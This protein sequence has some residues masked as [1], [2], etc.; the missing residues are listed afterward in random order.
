[1]T[2]TLDSSRTR[3]ARPAVP[4][5]EKT[6]DWVAA[7]IISADQARRID[8]AEGDLV[9]VAAG[10]ERRPG[11]SLAVEALGY[12]GG[13]VVV[14]SS[15]LIA[16]RYWHQLSDGARTS[17]VAVA[18]L[19][20][21]G[22]GFAIPGRLG[23]VGVRLRSVLWLAATIAWGGF[24]ALM[25]NLQLGM[26][27][28]DVAVVATGGAALLAAALWLRHQHFVQQATLAVSLMAACATLVADLAPG[29]DSLPGLAVWAV[30]LAWLLLAWAPVL[31]PRLL[32]VP[33]AAAAMVVGAMM[34][35]PADAG[36]VLSLAT[37]TSIV[38]LAVLSTDLLL[39]AVGSVGTLMVLPAIVNEWFPDSQAMPFVLLGFGLLLVGVAVWT[40]RRRKEVAVRTGRDWTALPVPWAVAGAA[41]ALVAA[42]GVI[43]MVA[44]G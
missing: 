28:I 24:L 8:D 41:A 43:T 2:T 19:A 44:L 14:V 39:L 20:L 25:C 23:E 17:V 3:E 29:H 33:A 12:L 30:G 6:D 4:L 38:A 26:H 15:I 31:G 22:A 13:V 16:T 40:A 1:M 35:T 9:L 27:G 34:T 37:V 32:A 42:A 11:A 7:G 10:P 21:L 36:M 18:S 5:R